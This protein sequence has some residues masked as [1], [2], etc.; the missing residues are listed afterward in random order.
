MD[1]ILIEKKKICTLY[2]LSEIEVDSFASSCDGIID[3][4]EFNKNFKKKIRFNQYCGKYSDSMIKKFYENRGIEKNGY[5]VIDLFCGAGGSSLG[6]KLAGFNLVGALDINKKAAET[7]EIN[8]PECKTIVGDITTLK[9]EQFHQLIGNPRVDILI[10]SPPCQTFSS[11]SQGKIKSLGK[12]IKTDVRN[13]FY[14][15]YLDYIS[16]FKPKFFLMENVPGFQTKYDGAIF[17][18]YKKYIK[19]NLPDYII[20]FKV[21]DAKN[22]S[23][24]QSRKRFFVCGH[25]K[26]YQFDFPTSNNFLCTGNDIVTVNDAFSDLPSISDDWRLEVMPYESKPK[27]LYQEFM[28]A[29]NN[30]CINN[31][32]RVSNKEAKEFFKLLKPNGKYADLSEEERKQVTLFDTFNSTVIQSR[33]HRLPINDVSWT[34]IAHIGMDGYEYIHPKQCRTISVREAARLQSF[35]DD[36]IFMGNM[37]EQYVQI[38]NAVPPLLSYSIASTILN[39]LNKDR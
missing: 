26:K 17:E 19:E 1:K 35:P 21:L 18:D 20:D 7:H 39:C 14:K 12:D 6:F 5:N 2:N 8:F 33:C 23:V 28:R 37:R 10:G 4:V 32:C 15:Y 24:P 38:G 36:F 29:K 16:Y 13:Y 31:V 3:L 25:L 11:L 9:P 34:I 27:N 30:I 22:Y